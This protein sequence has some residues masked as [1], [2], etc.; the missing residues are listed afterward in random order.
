M[1]KVKTF[2]WK[3]NENRTL[4]KVEDGEGVFIQYGIDY[5]ELEAGPG[6]F[7]AAIVEMPD[8]SVKSIPVDLIQFIKN[9]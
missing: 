7:T 5:E 6:S 2:R 1:R 4:Q 3:E 8:G 9:A